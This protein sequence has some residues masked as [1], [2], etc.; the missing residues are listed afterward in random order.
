MNHLQIQNLKQCSHEKMLL[1]MKSNRS[2]CMLVISEH[3]RIRMTMLYIEK[4]NADIN[5]KKYNRSI[6]IRMGMSQSVGCLPSKH[7]DLNSDP[8]HPHNRPVRQRQEVHLDLIVT[9]LIPGSVRD[10]QR[11]EGA[12]DLTLSTSYTHTQ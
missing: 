11:S 6:V 3:Q 10:S 2:R 9:S 8:Q 5:A 1:Y 7:E 4:C 12:G